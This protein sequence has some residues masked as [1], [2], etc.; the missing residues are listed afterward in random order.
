[1]LRERLVER[2]RLEHALQHMCPRYLIMLVITLLLGLTM[3]AAKVDE[4]A[5]ISRVLVNSFKLDEV[6]KE[7]RTT[8]GLR[9]FLLEFAEKSATFYPVNHAFVPDPH[10]IKI[11]TELKRYRSSDALPDLLKPTLKE[12]FTLTAWV[13]ARTDSWILRT[14]PLATYSSELE[15][16]QGQVC[17]GW[18]YPATLVYGSH[19]D[20]R[21]CHDDACGRRIRGPWTHPRHPGEC[22]RKPC[23]ARPAAVVG[24]GRCQSDT[25]LVLPKRSAALDIGA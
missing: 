11:A 17:W 14:E 21:C 4:Q 10:Q 24:G 15:E 2:I 13:G 19:D 20:R 18:R 7:V 23:E 6:V 12:T 8:E 22:T 25:R 16:G 5:T 9:A 1:M 3:L